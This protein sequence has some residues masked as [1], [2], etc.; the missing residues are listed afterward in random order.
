[1]PLDILTILD[2]L[3][4]AGILV[5]IGA[6]LWLRR[7]VARSSEDLIRIQTRLDEQGTAME[8]KTRAIEEAVHTLEKSLM[9]IQHNAQ[10]AVQRSLG[11]LQ[12]R[13]TEASGE[14][15]TALVERFEDL[16]KDVGTQ[17]GDGRVQSIRLHGRFP[18]A[19]A[20]GV[21]PAPDPL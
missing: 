5:T 16:K 7:T 2:L 9:E 10:H 11:E 18:R 1:M 13:Y 19:D 14:L 20:S 12:T 17:L 6:C 21:Q 3:I 8:S 4:L 15:R